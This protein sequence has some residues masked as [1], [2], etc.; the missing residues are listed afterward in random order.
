MIQRQDYLM[1][2][3]QSFMNALNKLINGLNERTAEETSEELESI[4]VTYFD[5]S[6]TFI[7]DNTP[8]EMLAWLQQD[9]DAVKK[10]EMLAQLLEQDA[11]LEQDIQTKRNLLEKVKTLL[12]YQER[13]SGTVSL[14]Q[15]NQLAKIEQQLAEL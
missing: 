1:R 8:E 2:M 4:Y 13:E 14:V 5:K 6:R 3:I 9:K 11:L 10:A 15:R 12:L 7:L